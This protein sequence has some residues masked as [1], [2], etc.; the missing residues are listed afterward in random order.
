MLVQAMNYLL[1]IKKM[2]LKPNGR[3]IVSN[4]QSAISN[5]QSAISNQQ[6][7]IS[8]QQSAIS[9]QQSAISNQQSAIRPRF[10]LIFILIFIKRML[11]LC[12]SALMITTVFAGTPLWTFEPKT[13]TRIAMPSNSTALVQYRVTNQSSKSHRLAIRGIGGLRQITTGP[14]VCSNP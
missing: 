13:A 5:Q 4:Q 3:S 7:A 2:F 6:S 9:N 10:S 11:A 8:N 12:C 14:T 1:D